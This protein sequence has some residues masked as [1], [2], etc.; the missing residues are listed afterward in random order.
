VRSEIAARWAARQGYRRVFRYAAGYKDWRELMETLAPGG[1]SRLEAGDLFPRTSFA[2]LRAAKDRPYLGLP[3]DAASFRLQD[4]SVPFLLV[5]VYNDLCTVCLK[6]MK[7]YGRVADRLA[8]N[9]ELKSRVRVVGIGMGETNRAAVRMRRK[10]NLPYPLFADPRRDLFTALGKPMLPALY[11]LD[12]RSGDAV[13]VAVEPGHEAG[14]DQTWQW[15][16]S[17]L[18]AAE[19]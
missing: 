2:V 7:I 15:L 13:I 8:R 11:L 16:L 17:L 3:G 19:D 5:E 1:A 14:V 4:S 9:P 6:Q 12:N 18:P 10:Q